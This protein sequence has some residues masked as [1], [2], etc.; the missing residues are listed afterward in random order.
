MNK[1]QVQPGD[2]VKHFKGNTYK[3]IDIGVDTE[4]LDKVVIYKRE[5]GTGPVW[6]RPLQMFNEIVEDGLPIFRIV[7]KTASK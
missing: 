3:V 7:R 2:V 6:V 5:D 4:T 1:N